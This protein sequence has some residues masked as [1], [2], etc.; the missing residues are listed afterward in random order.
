M[1][2]PHGRGFTSP[3]VGRARSWDKF[4]A[5]SD[6]CPSR[7][8]IRTGCGHESLKSPRSMVATVTVRSPASSIS[9]AGMWVT[10]GF[11]PSGARRVYRCLKN[12]PNEH[13]SG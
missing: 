13:A 12:S 11:T 7:T 5:P 10:T 3:S 1:L 6:I 9:K 4:E 2:R 8:R